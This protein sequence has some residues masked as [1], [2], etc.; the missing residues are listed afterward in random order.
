M[1]NMQNE[2]RDYLRARKTFRFDIPELCKKQTAPY[3]YPRIVHFAEALPK[4]IS[5]KI[6]RVQLREKS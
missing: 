1:L 5:G 2:Y 6:R 3:E 4:T